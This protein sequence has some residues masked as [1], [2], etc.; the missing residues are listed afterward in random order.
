[1]FHILKENLENKRA[2]H[3]HKAEYH[4]RCIICKN[5]NDHGNAE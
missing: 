3:Y 4:V 5:I 2:L 1:M